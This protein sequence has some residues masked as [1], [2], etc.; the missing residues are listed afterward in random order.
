MHIANSTNSKTRNSSDQTDYKTS[1]SSYTQKPNRQ[2]KKPDSFSWFTG[3]GQSGDDEVKGMIEDFTR[4][5]EAKG[6]VQK[7]LNDAREQFRSQVLNPNP[8]QLNQLVLFPTSANVRELMQMKNK[9]MYRLIAIVIALLSVVG[10]IVV[11]NG[12]GDLNKEA[13]HLR[14]HGV[15]ASSS[16][17][18]KQHGFT[19]WRLI[20]IGYGLCSA[21]R[22]F[23]LIV[24]VGGYFLPN[25]KVDVWY[26]EYSHQHIFRN[27]GYLISQL[28]IMV[29]AI[30][31]TTEFDYNLAPR[32]DIDNCLP[33]QRTYLTRLTKHGPVAYLL[34]IAGIIQVVWLGLMALPWCDGLNVIYLLPFCRCRQEWDDLSTVKSQEDEERQ[35]GFQ[36]FETTLKNNKSRY[37]NVNS[38]F[39]GA[40]QGL[41]SLTTLT[42]H[43]T[44]PMNDRRSRSSKRNN[45]SI[46]ADGGG[47]DDD[48]NPSDNN[49][50]DSADDD[51]KSAVS[52]VESAKTKL[53]KY[54]WKPLPKNQ[55]NEEWYDTPPWLR[56]LQL[57]DDPCGCFILGQGSQRGM[58]VRN[59]GFATFAHNWY[60]SFRMHIYVYSVLFFI[61][62]MHQYESVYKFSGSP[63]NV[64]W[65][66]YVYSSTPT[67]STEEASG[68]RLSKLLQTMRQLQD[69][70]PNTDTATANTPSDPDLMYFP[71]G[72]SN[73][74][75]AI[76]SESDTS[77]I[78]SSNTETPRSLDETNDSTSYMASAAGW[79][80]AAEV[81]HVIS[82]IAYWIG[83]ARNESSVPASHTPINQRRSVIRLLFP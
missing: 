38:S 75:F 21:R 70:E 13:E 9:Q 25:W 48:S 50:N 8:N 28:L 14:L 66:I 81:F 7:R 10:S 72:Q 17:I 40:A 71:S 53:L 46:G 73:D 35:D 77:K 63:R 56:L 74:C 83:I 54:E 43:G 79:W 22:L 27:V 26:P 31:A 20:A 65:P 16:A 19:G 4:Q 49:G 82:S 52:D 61:A 67:A 39:K 11:A 34:F 41:P 12:V 3:S 36:R 30:I 68:R 32:S 76:Y 60:G 23:S 47:S 57:Y 5:Y 51:T 42:L 69:S 59:C 24:A 2:V 1:S 45:V 37:E 29:S 55:L 6:D 62:S 15:T 33:F 80:M 18:T 64:T 58:Q 44:N 78:T